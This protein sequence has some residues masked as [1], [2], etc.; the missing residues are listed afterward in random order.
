[1]FYEK[2]TQK[3]LDLAYGRFDKFI[4]TL[5]GAFDISTS[6]DSNLIEN[7]NEIKCTRDCLIHADGKANVLY[8]QKAGGKARVHKKGDVL[9]ID[10]KYFENSVS[11]TLTLINEF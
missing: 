5:L 2:A 1:M 8:L 10:Y 6:I 3:I 7:V 4:A 9:K 11:E